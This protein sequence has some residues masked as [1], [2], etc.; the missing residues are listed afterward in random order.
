MFILEKTIPEKKMK[1]M[2]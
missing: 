2:C 1:V